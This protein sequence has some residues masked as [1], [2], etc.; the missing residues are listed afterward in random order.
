MAELGTFFSIMTKFHKNSNILDKIKNILLIWQIPLLIFVSM[1]EIAFMFY[2][3]MHFWY[4]SY[5][6]NGKTLE[7]I[8]F[9]VVKRHKMCYIRYKIQNYI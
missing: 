3:I 8:L 5:E 9:S 6:N 4:L 1:Q 2:Q 7:I